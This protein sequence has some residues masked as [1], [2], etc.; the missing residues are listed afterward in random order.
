[1]GPEISPLEREIPVNYGDFVVSMLVLGGVICYFLFRVVRSGVRPADSRWSGDPGGTSIL[2]FECLD[3]CWI[4]I[5]PPKERSIQWKQVVF[6][7]VIWIP[8]CILMYIFTFEY[9]YIQQQGRELG[10]LS[11]TM[12][13]HR[14][15][16]FHFSMHRVLDFHSSTLGL[17]IRDF[18]IRFS[19]P[20]KQ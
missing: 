7:L 16:I 1:M 13:F 6:F 2:V 15:R 5:H 14:C 8:R 10:G 18:S 19:G 4:K 20:G 11:W 3:F 12:I 17:G 9:F